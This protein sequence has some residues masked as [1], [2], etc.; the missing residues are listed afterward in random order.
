MELM[1]EARLVKIMSALLLDFSRKV[2]WSI[3]RCNYA[4][5]DTYVPGEMV[6]DCLPVK[7]SDVSISSLFPGP[8]IFFLSPRSI[9]KGLLPGRNGI[10]IR[11]SGQSRWQVSILVAC[12]IL[13]YLNANGRCVKTYITGFFPILRDSSRSVRYESFFISNYHISS[14]L[15]KEDVHLRTF[16]LSSSGQRKIQIKPNE[17]L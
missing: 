7:N 2:G 16:V 6:S 9:M 5:I 3:S 1:K 15:S 11:S 4:G 13:W 12:G 14:L 10:L 8:W 17:R